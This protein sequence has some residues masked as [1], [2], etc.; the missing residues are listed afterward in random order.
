MIS[1]RITPRDHMSNDHASY[2]LNTSFELD[3]APLLHLSMKLRTSGARYSGVVA[4]IL[5]ASLKMK[6]DP[7]SI[8][9]KSVILLP[10]N[11][12]KMLSGLRSACTMSKNDNS[13]KICKRRRVKSLSMDWS[14]FKA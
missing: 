12:T 9:F 8:S 10:S 2:F 14:S 5:L 3:I 6:A 13:S 1:R 4:G 11:E 7:K